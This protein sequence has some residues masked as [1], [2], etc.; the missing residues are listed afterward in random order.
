MTNPKHYET[1]GNI[2]RT[3]LT[4]ELGLGV[5]ALAGGYCFGFSPLHT[6]SLS[7]ESL[8][9]NLADIAWG[10]LATIPMLGLL[11]IV[12]TVTWGPLLRFRKTVEELIPS[13]FSRTS[14]LELALISLAAGIGEEMLFRGFLQTAMQQ[15]LDY[16]EGKWIALGAASLVFGVCHW[17]TPTYAVFATLIGLYL[18]ALLISS[19][20]LV[21]PIVAHAL[22]DFIALVYLVKWK[23]SPG[24]KKSGLIENDQTA[25]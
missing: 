11:V 17:L 23:G 10:L 13:L 6:I 15:W 8:P 7:F 19:E 5:A 24:K 25:S 21:V 22:Y 3:A 1:P 20:T 14:V 2:T 12:E 16:P 9:Q 4:V 18:G